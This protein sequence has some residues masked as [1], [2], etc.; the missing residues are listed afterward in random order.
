[1]IKLKFGKGNAKLDKK[2]ATF[3]LPAGH[4]CPGADKC[5][6]KADKDTGRITD[7]P[8]TEFRCFSASQEGRP[9]VRNSRWH[10]LRLLKQAGLKS[11]MCALI[12]N[13]LPGWAESVRIHVAGD[14][15]SQ[16]Y[17]D[18]WME[19]AELR[20]DI[21]FYAYTK[22]I[23]FWIARK[24][25]L[26]A[27]F[28]LTAS[29]G[30]K[31]DALIEKHELPSAEVIFHPDEAGDMKIDHDDSL[32]KAANRDSFCLLLHG[33][34]APKGRASAA[35]KRMRDENIEYSYSTK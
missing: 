9:G 3:S 34:Q 16:T 26:P 5:L 22:S 30:G 2:T 1:M 4:T 18:A 12:L 19:V 32:A 29:K 28:R 27:N 24:D 6:S 35:L 8:D 33:T 25:K 31:Y 10:N 15:F 11:G 23:P 14:F 13:A 20:P 7:G 17:F 21:V